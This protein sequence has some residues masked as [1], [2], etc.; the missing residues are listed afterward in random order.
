MSDLT[1]TEWDALVRRVALLEAAVDR[2]SQDL[3]TPRSRYSRNPGDPPPGH[4]RVSGAPYPVPAA[5]LC[6]VSEDDC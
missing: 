1:L 4:V 6:G 5:S 3:A 2:L